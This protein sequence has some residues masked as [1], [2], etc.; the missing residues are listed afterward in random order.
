[1][2]IQAAPVGLIGLGL[3][4]TIVARRLLAAGYRVVGYDIGADARDRLAALGGEAVTSIA[5]VARAC[6]AVFI[7][8]FDT[9]QLETVT[10]GPGGLASIDGPRIAINLATCDPDRVA[11]LS[12][13][14]LPMGLTLVEMPISGTSKQIADGDGVGLLGGDRTALATV[15]P[16]LQ[17][18]CPLCHIVGKIGDGARAKLAI[19]L[20]LGLN[21]AALAEGLAFA[22]A[23]GLDLPVFLDIARS[24]AAY[25]QIMDVKGRKMIERDFTA[26]GHIM[27]TVKD[28]TLIG[29]TGAG[30]GQ[31]LPLAATYLDLAK[32]CAAADEGALDNCAIIE[33]IRRRRTMPKP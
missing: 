10:E 19:N 33:E 17:A 6:P 11:A 14:L 26:H 22:E 13:R 28:F 18:V 9:A 5:D 15:E 27:Q 24:S 32:G 2:S 3:I 1:M 23:L 4:G 12:T 31:P 25:S 7:A 29:A 20:I 21:R 30:V 16:M 8:V